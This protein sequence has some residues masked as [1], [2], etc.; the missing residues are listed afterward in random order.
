MTDLF[1]RCV[2]KKMC[3]DCDSDKYALAAHFLNFFLVAVRIGELGDAPEHC[4]GHLPLCLA[5]DATMRCGGCNE[6]D[7]DVFE[8]QIFNYVH[9]IQVALH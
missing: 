7:K 3:F 8:F 6:S 9:E 1:V 5:S 2:R 4:V